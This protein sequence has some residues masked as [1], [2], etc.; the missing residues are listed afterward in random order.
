MAG[1]QPVRAEGIVEWMERRRRQVAAWGPEAEL[2]DRAAWAAGGVAGELPYAPRPSDV[3]S[4]GARTVQLGRG[5][6]RSYPVANSST[7]SAAS[8]RTP[9]SWTSARAQVRPVTYRPTSTAGP[10]A[11]PAAAAGPRPTQEDEMAKLRREQAAF[12]E[13]VREESRRNRWMAIPA[14][15]P[16]A[17]PLLAEGAALLTGRLAASQLSRAPLNLLGREPGLA[18]KPPV[19][20]P[21]PNPLTTPEKTAL[22][23][24][25][26][27]RYAQ[28]NPGYGKAWEVE[29]HHRIDLRF[30]HLFPKADPNRLANLAALQ[31]GAHNVVTQA[32]NRF[33]RALGREPTPTEVVAHKLEL[34]KLIETDLVRAGA[35]RPPPGAPK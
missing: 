22:R 17:V 14:L 2:A 26:R 29:I 20:A 1:L 15:A 23:D 3:V 13:V 31:K 12:K 19:S 28:A 25:A 7:F 27:T 30:S 10:M 21:R 18:P 8:G 11:P 32:T 5:A 24:A 9:M 35:P 6:E 34:D 4:L 33:L 16:M